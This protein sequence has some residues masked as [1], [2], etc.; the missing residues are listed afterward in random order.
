[1][2][3]ELLTALHVLDRVAAMVSSGE[4]PASFD[5]DLRTSPQ[6]CQLR[7]VSIVKMSLRT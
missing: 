3:Q 4:F 1:M 2:S 5:P 7:H 6:Q